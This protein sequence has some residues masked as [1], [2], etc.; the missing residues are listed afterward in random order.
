MER[1]V[2]MQT[3]SSNG[4]DVTFKCPVVHESSEQDAYMPSVIILTGAD[5]DH[6]ASR[7]VASTTTE[8]ITDE[9]ASHT[10]PTNTDLP[11][12]VDARVLSDESLRPACVKIGRAHV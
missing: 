8:E 4:A 5:V 7:P 10:L 12:D 11:L 2:P 1:F 9:V 3:P 6:T